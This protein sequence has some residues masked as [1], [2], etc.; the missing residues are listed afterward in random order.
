MLEK[1][2]HERVLLVKKLSQVIV[3]VAELRAKLQYLQTREGKEMIAHS[4]GYIAE[5]EKVIRPL[6]TETPS[7]QMLLE[8]VPADVDSEVAKVICELHQQSKDKNNLSA[9]ALKEMKRIQRTELKKERVKKWV[10]LATDAC[11]VG[12]HH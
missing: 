1:L 4:F 7:R 8:L 10:K 12:M 3:D 2:M 6:N 11:W 5:G 9:N